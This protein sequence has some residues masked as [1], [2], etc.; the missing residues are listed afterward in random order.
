M[1]ARQ[2]IADNQHVLIP[3]YLPLLRVDQ[4]LSLLA[5]YEDALP[6]HHE[7]RELYNS[8]AKAVVEQV[9]VHLPEL[10][11]LIEREKGQEESDTEETASEPE[12][13]EIKIIPVN[14][15]PEIDINAFLDK[16]WNRPITL[17]INYAYLFNL[18]S[19]IHYRRDETNTNAD[20]KAA[21]SLISD[22]IL[23]QTLAQ[24]PECTPV[25]V[26]FNVPVPSNP[27]A[28]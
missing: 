10:K 25:H 5:G 13:V 17:T 8:I 15:T 26:K 11:E 19:C 1:N 16:H 6:P 18:L 14:G 4:I 3:L 9:F 22:K 21:L 7:D 28:N 2:Y 27:D 23:R 20:E 24:F 12:I